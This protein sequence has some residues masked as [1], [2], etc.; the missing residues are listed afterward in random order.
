VS[1][2]AFC[3]FSFAAERTVLVGVGL[4]KPPYIIQKN[5]SGAELEIVKR[6]L[7][8]A[9]YDMRIRYMPLKRISH[10]LNGGMLDAGM[11]LRAYMAVDGFFSN[12]IITYQNYAITRDGAG[13]TLRKISDLASFRVTAFQNASRLLGPEFQNAVAL[14]RQYHEVA[15]QALQVK[16]LVKGRTDVVISDFRIFLHFKKQIEREEKQKYR[17][18][19]H[20]L[21]PKSPYRVAFRDKTIRDN[22]DQAIEEMRQSGEYDAILQ[23][24]IDEEDLPF[25]N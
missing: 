19:F 12:E 21:F 6:G 23:K 5:N 4:S 3:S 7:E 25:I 13:I 16:M 18:Q 24:Y 8:V 10:E 14:N 15:N 17:I 22:F 9:G 11:S 20:A 1:L 2:I